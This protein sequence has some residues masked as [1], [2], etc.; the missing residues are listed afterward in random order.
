M[1][2]SSVVGLV[3]NSLVFLTIAFGSLDFLA[4]QV[5]GKAWGVLISLPLIHLVRRVVPA[6]AR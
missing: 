1:I 2:A 6:P 4:G 3:V 5:V